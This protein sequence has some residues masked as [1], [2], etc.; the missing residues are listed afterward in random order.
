MRWVPKNEAELRHAIAEGLIEESHHC[1]LKRMLATGRGANRDIAKDLAAMAVDGGALIYGVDE[2][3]GDLRPF[4]LEGFRERVDQ[5]SGSLVDEPLNVRVEEFLSTEDPSRGYAVVLVPESPTAPHMVDGRYR[6]RG[7]TTNRV[8]SDAEVLRLHARRRQAEEEIE[9]LIRKEIERDPTP[10][11]KRE[12]AHMFVIAEPVS[13]RSEMLLETIGE[14]NATKWI[15]EN[16][17]HGRPSIQLTE[18]WSP[19]L[20]GASSVSRA[21]DG[22]SAHSSYI[23]PGRQPTSEADEEDFFEVELRENGGARLFCSRASVQHKD[24]SD[25]VFSKLSLEA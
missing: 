22:W 5:I 10:L 12:Q 8:L 21:A 17:I 4:H 7:D 11:D 3:N 14:E 19:D 6:G 24:V 25:R 9:D 1:D 18:G 2:A 15:L 20:G 16:L 13:G 23:A